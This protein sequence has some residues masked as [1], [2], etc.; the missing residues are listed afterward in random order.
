MLTMLRT[1]ACAILLAALLLGHASAAERPRIVVGADRN[2][3]P[4]EFQE[5]GVASGFN[6]ELMRS[7]ADVMGFDVLIQSGPWQTIKRDFLA[8]NIDVLTGMV[9]S[10]ER[11]ETFAFSPPHTMVF[12]A[13]FVR[14]N[15]PIQSI[16][17][18][19]GKEIVVQEDGMMHDIL[20]RS[21]F[22]PRII[23]V[24]A[25]P[26]ALRLVASGKYDGALLS[27]TM[28][29]HYIAKTF[30]LSNLRVVKTDMPPQQYCFAVT[31]GNEELLYTLNEGLNILKST[32]KYRELYEKWFGV[33]E[34][35]DWW[36]TIKYFVLALACIAALFIASLL[37]SRSLQK[38]VQL[39]TAELRAS[40]ENLR[41]A[42]TELEKRVEE[43]TTDLAHKTAEL[44][45]SNKEL[46]LFAS[47]ASHDLRAPLSTIGGFAQLL[48]ERY[49]DKLDEKA[50]RA[51]GHIVKGTEGMDM[52]IR[53][54][55]AYAR[56]T[57]GAQTLVPVSCKSIV[58]IVP[59]NLLTD[60]ESSGATITVD[61]LPTVYG[62]ETQFIQLFQNLVGNAIKYRGEQPPRIHIAAEKIEDPALCSAF[63]MSRDEFKPCWLFTV[64][65]NGIGIDPAHVEKIFE[66]FKRGHHGDK[67][68]G[69]GIGLA[70]CKKIVE[71]HGG[72][73]WVKS[74]PG[75]GS[76]FFFTIPNRSPA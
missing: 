42:H 64:S 26:E 1:I 23:T 43:R 75:K 21:A 69:T 66:I 17:D 53:D 24:P 35:R 19:R 6:V 11:A 10:E 8:G 22:S 59:T 54:L 29:G 48:Q 67:Y 15:S 13:L 36:E 39:Q 45:R 14:K 28:H 4:Y 55:L 41:K 68:A 72:K 9:Y 74:E 3:P 52:L 32:G 46:E 60:I 61:E 18:I 31:K 51:L 16:H 73:I 62:D 38:Q 76:T 30:G 71:R 40:G 34:E 25:Y 57:S 44:E 37:W 47:I 49:A 65:D 33:Y 20:I 70:V 2:Y 56:V 50:R 58:D 27:S 63:P 5:N 7:V 12:S